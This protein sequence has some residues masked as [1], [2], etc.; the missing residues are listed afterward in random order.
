MS[1]SSTSHTDRAEPRID[2]DFDPEVD[3]TLPSGERSDSLRRTAPWKG[4]IVWLVLLMALA[5]SA[6][7]FYPWRQNPP[8]Q[9]APAAPA[10]QPPVAA[11]AAPAIRHPIENAQGAA[12]NTETKP[13]PALMVSDTTMQNT[14]ADLFG[15]ASLGKVFY[16]DAIIHR[17][18]TTVDNLPR[19]TIPSRNLPVKPIGGPLVTSSKDDNISISADNASRYTPYV[20]MAESIDAKSLVS[21]YV[22]FYP[23]IQQDYRDLGYPKGY[24]NDRLIEAID[25]LLAAP[26]VKDSLQ[27]VQPKVLYQYADPELEA[28]SAGQKIMIRMGNDNA[29]KVKAKLQEIRRELTS[30]QGSPAGPQQSK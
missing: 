4:P 10:I 3:P 1:T 29:A 26:E 16:E 7:F 8:P 22:H 23:L 9:P 20:R 25:D 19:K 24:F 2:P 17:F 13:L 6:V 18:V 28:R 15:P 11:E 27:V 12:A 30:P 5:A 14:L 21:A